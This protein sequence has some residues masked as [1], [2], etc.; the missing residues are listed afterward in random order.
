MLRLQLA[1]YLMDAVLTR[2]AF[3]LSF[4]TERASSRISSN[5]RKARAALAST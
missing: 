4:G 1:P 5:G 3:K 2:P